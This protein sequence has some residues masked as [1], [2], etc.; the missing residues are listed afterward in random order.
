MKKIYILDKEDNNVSLKQEW[1]ADYIYA[2]GKLADLAK[3]DLCAFETEFDY[4]N[5]RIENIVAVLPNGEEVPALLFFW[6]RYPDLK[7]EDIEIHSWRKLSRE[8]ELE[9]KKDKLEWTIAQWKE[10]PKLY[11]FGLVVA[12]DD[13]ETLDATKKRFGK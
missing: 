7:P 9:E 8:E 11:A 12:A 5:D 1:F 3:F 10:H 6:H 13:I 2:H 4:S